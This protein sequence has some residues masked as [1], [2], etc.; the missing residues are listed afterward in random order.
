[1][2]TSEVISQLH[3]LN[4]EEHDEIAKANYTEQLVDILSVF[5]KHCRNQRVLQRRH[6]RSI[7]SN[8]SD[9]IVKHDR[10][11]SGYVSIF[12]KYPAMKDNILYDLGFG[13]QLKKT[14]LDHPGVNTGVYLRLLHKSSVPPGTLV[15]FVPGYFD[16]FPTTRELSFKANQLYRFNS[17]LFK[18]NEKLPYPFQMHSSKKLESLIYNE[19]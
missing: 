9:N 8:N 18:I 17:A 3:S 16:R 19:E 12:D 7:S 10:H 6:A 1:M 2:F 4:I 5:H 11:A 15:G 13:L 14:G